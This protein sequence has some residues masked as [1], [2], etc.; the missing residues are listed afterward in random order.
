MTYIRD[1]IFFNVCCLNFLFCNIHSK[2]C[3]GFNKNYFILSYHTKTNLPVGRL[4]IVKCFSIL[5]MWLQPNMDKNRKLQ[6]NVDNFF[7]KFIH[8]NNRRHGRHA[9]GTI[10]KK[11]RNNE[12]KVR[13]THLFWAC[14]VWKKINQKSGNP[15]EWKQGVKSKVYCD[16]PKWTQKCAWGIKRHIFHFCVIP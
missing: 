11:V 2:Y 15:L 7:H 5:D 6:E 8:D 12:P 16:E 1:L 4:V 10:L 3:I 14:L 9:W 13:F